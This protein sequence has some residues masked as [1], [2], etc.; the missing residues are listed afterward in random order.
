MRPFRVLAG[1]VDRTVGTDAAFKVGFAF[2]GG[3]ANKYP[4]VKNISGA[5]TYTVTHEQNE[6]GDQVVA[7]FW[8]RN[9]DLSRLNGPAVTR[10]DGFTG[11][12]LEEYWYVNGLLHRRDGPAAVVFFAGQGK[13]RQYEAWA[14]NGV[15]HRH[16]G[17]ARIWYDECTGSVKTVEHHPVSN[18][19]KTKVP[20]N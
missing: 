15:Y 16:G 8:S 11:Q 18:T 3:F 9:G 4:M 1:L 19:R 6:T 14:L 5:M 17:P 10:W 7:E 12:K 2:L 13:N 20:S